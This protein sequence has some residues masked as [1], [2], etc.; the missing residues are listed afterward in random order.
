MPV[1][2]L[3]VLPAQ[4]NWRPPPFK[5]RTDLETLLSSTNAQDWV[6]ISEM[7]LGPAAPGFVFSPKH[8]SNAYTT[9]DAD[10]DSA[11]GS[12]QA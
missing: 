7:L 3:E 11:Y 6:R 9:T 2:L 5:G 1:G 8:T 10:L 4:L 12:E